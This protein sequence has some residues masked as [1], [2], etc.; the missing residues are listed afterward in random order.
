MHLGAQ[1]SR[2]IR[3]GS[4][5]W[6]SC[7][8]GRAMVL[9]AKPPPG[10]CS[11]FIC[12]LRVE[13]LHGLS[14]AASIRIPRIFFCLKFYSA[15][16]RCSKVR[17]L[18]QDAAC[19]PRSLE[20]GARTTTS[21]AQATQGWSELCADFSDSRTARARPDQSMAFAAKLRGAVLEAITPRMLSISEHAL[22]SRVS[23]ADKRV[24]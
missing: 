3:R 6:R 18:K 7:R 20:R 13:L 22:F 14:C 24:R 17:S 4:L 21:R 2:R 1:R 8:V 11:I 9:A 15:T 23:K 19:A 16:S 10:L 5:F 12:P